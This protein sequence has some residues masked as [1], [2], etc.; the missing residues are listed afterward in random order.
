VSADWAGER[1]DLGW[2][3]AVLHPL[4]G[5]EWTMARKLAGDGGRQ[6]TGGDGAAVGA[7]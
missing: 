5:R 7:G 3:L 2:A 6:V 4:A 1:L